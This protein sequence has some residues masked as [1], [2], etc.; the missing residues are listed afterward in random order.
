MILQHKG[1]FIGCPRRLLSRWP[2]PQNG[3]NY[4]TFP[5]SRG[6]SWKP[7]RTLKIDLVRSMF[8]G[9]GPSWKQGRIMSYLCS[10]SR[11]TALKSELLTKTCKL[12]PFPMTVW[13]LTGLTDFGEKQI[14]FSVVNRNPTATLKGMEKWGRRRVLFTWK[15]AQCLLAS[16]VPSKLPASDEQGAWLMWLGAGTTV[17]AAPSTASSFHRII[18]FLI[19]PW[20]QC[21]VLWPLQSNGNF[22]EPFHDKSKKENLNIPPCYHY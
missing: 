13:Q 20:W 5:T 14:S 9:N 3:L 21:L 4:T 15:W 2:S 6:A 16:V 7:G 17:R 10:V 22:L 18:R 8:T 12:A 1:N 11:Y 19:A